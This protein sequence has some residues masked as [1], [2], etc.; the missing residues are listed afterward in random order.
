[1][2]QDKIWV[3][4]GASEYSSEDAT[5]H[6]DVWASS[7][8]IEWELITASANWTPRIWQTVQVYDDKIFMV[9]GSNWHT[10]PEENGN[11]SEIWFTDDGVDWLELP[12]ENIWSARHASFSVPDEA[13]GLLVAAGYGHGGVGRIYNDAWILRAS[14]YFSKP[15][16]DIHDLSTWGKNH[17][18]TGASP[19]SFGMDNQIFI[20]ANRASFAI[21]DAWSVSGAGS[22]I[23]VGDGNVNNP[24]WLD[25]TDG[26][27]ATRQ[28]YLSANSTTVAWGGSPTVLYRHPSA[29]LIVN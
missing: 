4:G 28:L 1:V 18:G 16:G 22:R 25:L 11:T 3:I 6:S 24:V 7:D 5:I 20:L 26:S 2:Y 13:G 29:T 14:I 10:W 21:D 27:P 19:A 12:S 17:D 8:G 9:N 15:S 23:I